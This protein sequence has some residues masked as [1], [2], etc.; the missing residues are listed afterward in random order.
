[1]AEHNNIVGA[2]AVG[3]GTSLASEGRVSASGAGD[4][5]SCLASGEAAVQGQMFKSLA[6]HSQEFIGMCDLEFGPFYVN[7]AGRRLVK[8]DSV[9][10]ACA[11]KVQDHFFP[12]D[13][14]FIME[15]FFPGVLRDP[16]QHHDRN[17]IFLQP[18]L[19]SGGVASSSAC[20]QRPFVGGCRLG[21][22]L[23][24]CSP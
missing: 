7:E 23:P 11:V 24:R 3:G 9:E 20:I 17:L 5:V 16:Q 21:S 2:S 4:R 10:E 19:R 22:L 1:V 18:L 8:L 6:D 12:E 15:E 13:Q 14:R